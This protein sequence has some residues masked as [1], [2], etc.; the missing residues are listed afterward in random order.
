MLQEALSS[1]GYCITSMDSV[2]K[3]LAHVRR[4][5]YVV[6]TLGMHAIHPFIHFLGRSE[7]GGSAPVKAACR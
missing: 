2:V 6:Q 7:H 5:W 4:A 1:A 3:G